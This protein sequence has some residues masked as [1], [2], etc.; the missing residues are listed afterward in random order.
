MPTQEARKFIL[1][2]TAML[3][4]VAGMLTFGGIVTNHPFTVFF[5][6]CFVL[7]TVV[8]FFNI[9]DVLR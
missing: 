1:S 7:V 3:T 6:G 9:V 4:V 8:H 2:I 5:N